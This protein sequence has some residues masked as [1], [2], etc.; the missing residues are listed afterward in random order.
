MTMRVY[1][2]V[3]TLHVESLCLGINILVV[4]KDIYHI[5]NKHVVRSE[6]NNLSHLALYTQWRLLDIR[7]AHLDTGTGCQPGLFPL[8]VVFARTHSTP[9]G[10]ASRRGIGEIDDKLHVALDDV[11]RMALGTYR[12]VAHGRVGADG[13][14]PRDGDDIILILR[15]AATYHYGGEGVYH[16]TGFPVLLHDR[17]EFWST[18]NGQ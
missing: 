3:G 6:R 9:V 2:E 13:A 8:V 5:G 17:V 11:G 18:D 10:G 14:R 15:S 7:R 16:C 4:G 12:D 1:H